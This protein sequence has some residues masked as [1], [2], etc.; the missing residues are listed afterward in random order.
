MKFRTTTLAACLAALTLTAPISATEET[1]RLVIA[2]R[3]IEQVAYLD[4]ME[5][6]VQEMRVND[7]D[8]ELEPGHPERGV[9]LIFPTRVFN[10]T[11]VT[12][13]PS[14]VRPALHWSDPETGDSFVVTGQ[15]DFSAVPA[16]ARNSGEFRFRVSPRDRERFDE[17]SA[18][19][20]FGRAGRSA[21][22][23]PIGAEVE[24]RSRLPVPQDTEGWT[25]V[26]EGELPRLRRS[27]E[28]TVT[29]T[30][31][32]VMWVLGNT[33]LEDGT[34][35]LEITYTIENNS[36]AQSCSQRGEGGWRLTLPNGDAVTD[37][38]VSERCVAQGDRVEGIMTGFMLPTEDFA[39]QYVLA[40]RRGAGGDS[41]D[42]WGEVEIRLEAGD[43]V[44]F[45]DRR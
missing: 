16:E 15:G 12:A 1:E 4:R 42:P 34:S 38:R 44:V 2:E 20:V 17:G 6:L 10:T 9:E 3:D 14:N 37:L 11:Q 19:L 7:L 27:F 41:G 5:F 33:P 35:L 32:E 43:G 30:R 40:H 28:D 8:A 24:G 39:G 31:A 45:L 21:A 22:I 13:Q 23:V 29:I 36:T 26:V 25:F 18:H